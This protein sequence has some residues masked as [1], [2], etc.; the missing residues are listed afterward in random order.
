MRA[1]RGWLVVFVVLGAAWAVVR[2]VVLDEDPLPVRVHEVALGRVER[3]V[4]S[5]RAGAIRSRTNA[6]LSVDCAG[7]I[8]AIH[9]R[10]GAR[11]VAGTHLLSL[12]R[13]EVDAAL[14]VATHEL[15]VADSQVSEARAR[16]AKADGDLRRANQ[17]AQSKV[18]PRTEL[19]QVQLAHE[20]A[21]A[22]LAAAEA[23]QQ[24][25][26]AVVTRAGVA[27]ERTDVHAPFD[28]V[29]VERLVEVGEWVIPGQVALRIVD[30]DRVYVQAE[31]DEVDQA[32]LA[33][34]MVARVTL[35]S[36]PDRKLPG[37]L[38]RIA[39]FVSELQEQ[40]RT[41]EVEVE[42][43][44]DLTNLTLRPG[45]SA[46][47]ECVLQQREGV[48]R[49]PASALLDGDR[50]LV[51]SADGQARAVAIEVGL[52]NWEWVEVRNGLAAGTPV[53]VSL[54]TERVKDGARVRVQ[55]NGP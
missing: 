51:A 14:G 41:V 10:E 43:E 15:S 50:V 16:L 34:G 46:D 23:R 45:T 19:E 7:T 21:R 27:V 26:R 49:L 44:G 13:R 8:V 3:T 17:L 52:R 18:I 6:A 55:G 38:V 32:G 40:N 42:L 2:F 31:I 35:D 20:V 39:P 12:D 48:L 47:V 4:A 33:V 53:I 24:A 37:R 54:E 30:P 1:W 22:T 5:T 29:V 28:G 36:Y 9:V 25:Q 11:V